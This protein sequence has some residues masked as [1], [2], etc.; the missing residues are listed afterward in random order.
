MILDNGYLYGLGAFETIAI[1]SGTPIF[2]TE[3][4]TRLHKALRFLQIG[5][6][7][8]AEAVGAAIQA[9]GVSHGALRLTMSEHN[10]LFTFRENPYTEDIYQRGFRLHFCDALRNDAS[11]L[12]YHKTLNYGDCILEKRKCADMG[13]D[14][15]IFQNH[16]GEICEG[17][18]S[19][20]FFV[21]G[22]TI[23]TPAL[24]CGLLPGILRAYLQGRYDI[25]E[26]VIK[27]EEI[28]D[29]D[30]CFVTNS[31]LGIMPVTSLG[32]VQFAA[33]EAAMRLQREYVE[34]IQ[35][36]RSTDGR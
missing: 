5:R 25:T 26:A 30:E 17:T 33:Q 10:T 2:L 15:G 20:I 9:E 22:N 21:K 6:T 32:D 34:C 11:P 12:T 14:E 16:R 24:T 35:R 36:M 28:A 19:N 18:T 29:F 31:L 3:H 7:V 1:K 4:L 27:T 13:Y 23:L 8:T